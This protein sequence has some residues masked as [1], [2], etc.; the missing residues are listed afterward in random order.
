MGFLVGT[1]I[2][3]RAP[4]PTMARLP[5]PW[6]PPLLNAA[7]AE[8]LNAARTTRREDDNPNNMVAMWM[9]VLELLPVFLFCVFLRITIVLFIGCSAV[10]CCRR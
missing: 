1:C 6:I 10:V 3:L 4:D 8:V 5:T 2:E 7:G 9:G